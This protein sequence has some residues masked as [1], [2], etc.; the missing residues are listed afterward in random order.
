MVLLA[1][2]APTTKERPAT[3]VFWGPYLETL[4]GG[5]APGPRRGTARCCVQLVELSPLSGFAERATSEGLYYHR[6]KWI[7]LSAV[8]PY[9]PGASGH[10]LLQL[11]ATIGLS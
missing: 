11:L 7:I 2:P 8:L 4:F 10:P 5:F 1:G 9:Y 6:D 3:Q